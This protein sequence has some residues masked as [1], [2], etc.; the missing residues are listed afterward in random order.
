MPNLDTK[1]IFLQEVDLQ[2]V[3]LWQQK[4]QGQSVANIG[5]PL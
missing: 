5:S 1:F 4:P 3:N 2:M